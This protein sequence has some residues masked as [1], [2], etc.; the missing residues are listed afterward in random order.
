MI[1]GLVIRLTT[2]E[3]LA[4]QTRQGI[5]QI[6]SIDFGV[7]QGANLPVVLETETPGQSHD[8]TDW[9][10]TLPGVEHV[11]VT[12]TSFEDETALDSPAGET[13]TPLYSRQS[14]GNENTCPTRE[15]SQRT[16]P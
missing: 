6:A 1:S 2:D 9:L 4:E 5:R 15:N 14:S 16:Q 12:F 7:Q 3:Q 13:D 8:L 10:N 11:D